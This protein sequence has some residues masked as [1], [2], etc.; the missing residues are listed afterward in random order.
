MK[1]KKAS[2]IVGLLSLL[3]LPGI[4]QHTPAVRGY[5]Y[6][7]T[8][9]GSSITLTLPAHSAVGDLAVLFFSNGYGSAYPP[10]GWTTLYMTPPDTNTWFTVAA[11]KV[12]T[13]GDINAG[14]VLVGIGGSFDIA[15][16]L[17]VYE[18][19]TV[20]GIEETEGFSTSGSGD[21]YLN[22]SSN[23]LA[24]DVILF[25]A[26][27]REDGDPTE[28]YIWDGQGNPINGTPNFIAGMETRN[29][30]SVFEYQSMKAGEFGTGFQFP[31]PGGGN[32][33]EGVQV[34][35]KCHAVGGTCFT[36]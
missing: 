29:T 5:T 9:G 22:T 30:W 32:G 11:S 2:Q 36:N 16:G 19:S 17:A 6:Q 31:T 14:S 27:D 23:P 33:E 12:L 21:Q 13:Q 1:L 34:V 24:G 7:A 28:P 4:A 3:T 10:T 18:G 25:W 26:S 20:N 8:S 35:V 15:G